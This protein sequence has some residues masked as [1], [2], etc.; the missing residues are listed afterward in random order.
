MR[1]EHWKPPPKVDAARRDSWV[2]EHP[3]A[4]PSPTEVESRSSAPGG[5]VE[6][7]VVRPKTPGEE[8]YVEEFVMTP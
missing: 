6:V 1:K 2:E 3:G 4:I 7:T 5:S 8:D